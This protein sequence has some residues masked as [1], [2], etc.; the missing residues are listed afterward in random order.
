MLYYFSGNIQQPKSTISVSKHLPF[1][2]SPLHFKLEESKAVFQNH[3]LFVLRV[4]ESI[5][6][7]II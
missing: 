7:K 2:I 4:L 6:V 1:S 3:F 5:F